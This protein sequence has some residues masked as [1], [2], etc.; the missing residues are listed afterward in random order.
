MTCKV[1]CAHSIRR[2]ETFRRAAIMET[3][4]LTDYGANMDPFANVPNLLTLVRQ[5]AG[6]Q[7]LV[8]NVQQAAGGAARGV[9]TDLAGAPIDLLSGGLSAIG[10][11]LGPRPVGGSAWLRSVTGQPAHESGAGLVGNLLSAI[12]N[13]ESLAGKGALLGGVGVTKLYHGGRL[14]GVWDPATIGTGEGKFMAQGPGL[15]AGDNPDLAKLYM[16]YGGASPTLTELTVDSTKIMDPRRRL[17][18]AQREAYFKAAAALDSLG[19]KAT[20]QGIRNALLNKDYYDSQLVRKILADSGVG[21]FRQDL[22]NNYGTE[23][24]IFDPSIILEYKLLEG[25]PK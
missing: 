17:E 7:K 14:R 25:V 4:N 2:Q 18:G 23:Y 12:I 16:K 22:N 10:V 1:R 9:T 8:S 20:D 3:T 21:G 5:D 19:F 6:I 13:P 11:P 15:Y 24:V